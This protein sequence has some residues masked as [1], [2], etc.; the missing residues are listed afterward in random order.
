[1]P[2]SSRDNFSPAVRRALAI[3]AAHFCSNPQ[4]LKLTAGPASDGERGL[5]TGHGAHIRGAARGG[6]RYDSNQTASE[7]SAAAN[8]I[9]LCRECGDIVDK[10]AA[11][12][13]AE[14]LRN[15]KANHEAMIAEV[16][17]KGWSHSIELLRKGRATPEMAEQI[18]ALFEDRRMFWAAF[19]AE[20][21]DRVRRS[22][23]GLRRDLTALR[24]QGVVGSPLD[25]IIIA[26]GRTIR[27]F[28]D[29]VE[30]F[31]LDTL[32][33]DS[34]DPEWR[35]FESAL[36]TLRKA[37]GYQIAALARAYAIPLQGEFADYQPLASD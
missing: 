12:H 24:H 8:G 4:C 13:T 30:R 14:D 22:L 15:W 37:I 2:N 20:M 9:W 6:P 31:D 27:H 29:A 5:E 16:R 32:R 33:C 10:D 34:G 21:P 36:R 35:A 18:I 26:L 11:G 19:D 25:A 17:T 1:M 23:D 3:R 28:F 7:R